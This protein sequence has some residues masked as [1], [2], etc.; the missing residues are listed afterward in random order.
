[1][2]NFSKMNDE[3][4]NRLLDEYLKET[5]DDCDEDDRR[6]ELNQMALEEEMFYRKFYNDFC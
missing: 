3:Y 5:Y 6:A 1:M 2:K 4:D